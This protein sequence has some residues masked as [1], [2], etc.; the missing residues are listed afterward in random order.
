MP[1]IT[2]TS[3]ST[4]S[5]KKYST[6]LKSPCSFL[7]LATI[8]VLL[9]YNTAVS[10]VDNSIQSACTTRRQILKQALFVGT[11]S[12]TTATT[13]QVAFAD[14][15]KSRTD[16]YA[17][18]HNEEE[19]SNILSRAQYNILRK[20]GTERQKSSVLNTFSSDKVGAYVCAGCNTPLFMSDAKFPSGTGWPSFATALSNVEEEQVNPIQARLDG[21]E[22][23][24][25]T[26][27]GH[28]GDLF[29]DGWLYAG[30][31][32]SKTGRRYCIDGAAL[33]FKPQNGGE[34][35]IGYVP[36][37][38]KDIQYQPSLYRETR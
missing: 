14:S 11:L 26:C 8:A 27:G 24:C 32:A 33:I 2:I 6:L 31:Q 12:T 17:V 21:R 3:N 38:S 7:F 5:Y 18:Q 25:G 35:V 28:L 29:N 23:R 4:T 1:I 9:K 30:T 34:D 15:T 16:G 13:A 37:P 22:V 36:P 20:G 19:W 10:L